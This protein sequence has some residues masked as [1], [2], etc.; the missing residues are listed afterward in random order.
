MAADIEEVGHNVSSFKQKSS[1]R[2]KQLGEI[3]SYF[4]YNG[5]EKKSKCKINAVT[6]FQVDI[7][8]T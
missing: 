4:T 6:I 8:Q 5:G 1:G 7:L 2:T 3:H